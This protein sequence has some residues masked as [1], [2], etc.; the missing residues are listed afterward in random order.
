MDMMKFE[1]LLKKNRH[2]LT[3]L[4]MLVLIIAGCDSFFNDREKE[5][6]DPREHPLIE[7]GDTLIFTSAENVDSFYVWESKFYLSRERHYDEDYEQYVGKMN[8]INY[9]DT[10]ISL[11]ISIN[12]GGYYV[13]YYYQF[14]NNSDPYI[15]G[16]SIYNSICVYSFHIWDTELRN[17]HMAIY[18]K[19]N[20]YFTAV[21][22]AYYSKTYGFVKYIKYTGEE[23]VLSEESLE[24]LIARE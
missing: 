8:L 11:G 22:T 17:I 24:M 19:E 7:E 14:R 20:S 16:S 9:K 18:L 1:K 10:T 23:F 12:S 13:D 15:R 6:F 21:D 2:L 4:L 3:I 5:R